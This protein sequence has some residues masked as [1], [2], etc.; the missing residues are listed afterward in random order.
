MANPLSLGEQ[1]KT[2]RM[3]TGISLRQFAASINI[4]APFLSDIELGRRFPSDEVLREIAKALDTNFEDLKT[5]DVRESVSEVRRMVNEDA[6]WGLAFRTVAQNAKS[7]GL[8]PSELMERLSAPLQ[9]S[10]KPK[11]KK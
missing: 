1:I 2:L 11:S 5:L 8:T 9:T 7:A 3:A 10:P 6:A 4:T